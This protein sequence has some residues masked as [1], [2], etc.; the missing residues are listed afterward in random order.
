MFKVGMI[1]LGTMGVGM[2]KNLANANF[3]TTIYNRTTEKAQTLAQELNVSHALS[4]EELAAQVNVICLC[5]SRDEDVLEVIEAISRT[6]LPNTIVIDMSTV[7][8]HTARQAA[9]ILA[10]KDVDFLDAPVSGGVEGAKN[11]TLAMMVGGNE[12]VLEKVHPVLASI[13]NRIVHVG[14]TGS[15]QATKAVNQIMAAGINQAVT[16]ALA[17]AKTQSLPMEKIIDV[18][19]GGAAGNWFL[20]H[21][22]MSMTQGLYPAGFKLEL[23]HKD[24][25]ICE[26]M[27]EKAGINLPLTTQTRLDYETLIA[28]G[29][30]DCDISALYH[31]KMK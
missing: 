28:E 25:K 18:I 4:I 5:V 21:R 23:H 19:S 16:E 30:S 3:L 1:G 27:G 8:S 31:L 20:Q 14:E 6:V 22:G 29:F 26:Q 24:L 17:F 11:G 15:G 7:S 12:R 2:A 10:C 9:A 13:A